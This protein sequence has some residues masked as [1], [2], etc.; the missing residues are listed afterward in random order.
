MPLA[1]GV[2]ALV[3]AVA[4]GYWFFVLRFI[5]TTDDAYVGGNVTLMAPRVSGFVSEILVQDNQR[6]RAN[7]VLMRLDARDYDA[8]LAQADAELA[9]ARAAVTE[10]EAQRTLQAAVIGQHQAE[11]R[12]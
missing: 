11:V 4:L 6:V 10:L 1:L 2:V 12:A 5:Q 9:S 7:Q 8:K 3:L